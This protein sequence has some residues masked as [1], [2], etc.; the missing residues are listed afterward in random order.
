M[1]LSTN[2]LGL[3]L[4]GPFVIGASPLGDRIE[5]IVE[6]ERCGAGAVVLRS[7]F[8]EQITQSETNRIRGMEL[9]EPAFAA[10]FSAYP[11]SGDYVFSPAAYVAHLRSVKR[12]VAIPII[13]SLNGTNVEPWL[14][15]APQ[16]EEAGADAIEINVYE[17]VTST[18]TPGLA[19]E[20]NLCE[21]V[22][23]L[24]SRLRV[25]IAVK[26]SPF[27]TAFGNLGHELARAGA[28]GLVMFNRVIQPDIDVETMAPVLEPTLSTNAELLLRLRWASILYGQLP[29]SLAVTGG[30]AGPTDGIKALLAGADVVQ[31]VS[32]V[33]RHGPGHVVAMRE[34]LEHWMQGHKMSSVAA[35]RGL[36]SSRHAP[37]QAAFERGSYIS[38]LQRHPSKTEV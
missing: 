14:H 38:M 8:E 31:L 15:I 4:A 1:D 23:A 2:Y 26:L 36:A 35:L 29:L 13:A 3:S 34:A 6:L 25:P 21:V 12:A 27:Y 9:V 17:L 37:D 5:T 10:R 28:A 33:L 20:S 30:V 32:A 16:L 18:A 24:R 22:K 7:L 11:S 19:I